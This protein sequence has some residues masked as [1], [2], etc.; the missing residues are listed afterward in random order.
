MAL[1]CVSLCESRTAENSIPRVEVENSIPR[2][3]GEFDIERE[4]RTRYLEGVENL[5]PRGSG[6]L[7]TETPRGVERTICSG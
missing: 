3:S 5:I 2:G 4:W 1:V 6:E 7:D